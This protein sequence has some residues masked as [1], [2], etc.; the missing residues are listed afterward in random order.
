L[1]SEAAQL[2][3]LYGAAAAR[4]A[5]RGRKKGA[6]A[7][8]DATEW[9]VFVVGAPRSG[10]TFM[11]GSLGRL[12]GFVDLGEVGPL[13]ASIHELAPLPE[14]EAARR[15]RQTLER[16][17]ALG[18]ARRLRAI[19]QTPET[20]FVLAAALRAYPQARA[21]HM[22]RDGRDVVCSLLAKGWLSTDRPGADDVGIAYGGYP[23]FWV[24]AE[25]IEEFERASD[26]RRAAWAWRRYLTAARTAVSASTLEVRYE[27][28]AAVPHAVAEPLAG[29]LGV[30]RDLLAQA[31]ADVHAESVGRWRRDL[32]EKQLADVEAEA[33]PLLRELGY[34]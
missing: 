28:L 26:A 10:T 12:P 17:R 2:L 9:P 21:V 7:R 29:H 13:K 24:E 4:A 25:R 11:A 31:L 16:V 19:E 23:R 33:G 15:I 6:R 5:R 3:R 20:S 27:E 8:R 34:A 32:S 1:A 18:L 14:E 30:D 22:V